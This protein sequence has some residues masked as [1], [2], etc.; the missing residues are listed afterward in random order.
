MANTE[1][2][3][4]DI[5]KDFPEFLEFVLE[6]T[7]SICQEKFDKDAAEIHAEV[8]DRTIALIR[9]LIQ[10]CYE[11]DHKDKH[12]LQCLSK[13]FAD[14]LCSFRHHIVTS[15]FTPTALF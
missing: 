11:V 2:V 8:I 6:K 10:D 7:Q 1:G 15:G 5:E 3:E 12:D 14:V 4:F 13:A 9:S